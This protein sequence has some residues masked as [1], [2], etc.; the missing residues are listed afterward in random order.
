MNDR[1][2]PGSRSVRIS[3]S[4]FSGSPVNTGDHN[5]VTV[6]PGSRPAGE[7]FDIAAELNAIRRLL[8]TLDTPNR[9]KIRCALTDAD[10]DSAGDEPHLGGKGA[11]LTGS[12]L[13]FRIRLPWLG[14][15][16]RIR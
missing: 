11:T 16:E 8:E 2:K 15:Q 9:D 7:A 14:G 6:S 13:R 1:D 12:T 4:K 10:E 5:T 3:G